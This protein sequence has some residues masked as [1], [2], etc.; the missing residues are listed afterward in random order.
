M[1][2]SLKQSIKAR[3]PQEKNKKLARTQIANGEE[4]PEEGRKKLIPNVKGY[5]KIENRTTDRHTSKKPGWIRML[6]SLL[7]K[8]SGSKQEICVTAGSLTA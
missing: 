5:Q 3:Y 1:R 4:Q 7:N 6:I 2:Q 8:I